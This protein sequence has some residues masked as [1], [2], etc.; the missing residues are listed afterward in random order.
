M[1]KHFCLIFL[2]GIVFTVYSQ[3]EWITFTDPRPSAPILRVI[4]STNQQVRFDIMIP[5]MYQEDTIIDQI[6][7][8]RLLIPQTGTWGVPGYPELPSLSKL[9]AVPECDSIT[10]SFQV[11]DSV[12]LSSYLVFPKPDI[13]ED[14]IHSGLIEVFFKN[15]SI[16]GLNATFPYFNDEIIESGYFRNQP[17]IR[18][19]GYPMHFNPA[20]Q[21]LVVYTHIDVTL[22]FQ[23]PQGV[24]NVDNGL[25]NGIAQGTLLNY[26]LDK[27]IAPPYPTAQIQWITMSDPVEA[28]NIYAD[29]LIITDA[30]FFTPQH[31][32]ALQEIASHRASY[33]GYQIAIVNVQNIFELDFYYDPNY[34][35]FMYEQKIRSFIKR[36]YEG[37]HAQHTLDG[38][39][40]Y[41][42]LV[43]DA[44][45][46]GYASLNYGVPT[47]NDF[48]PGFPT[49]INPT[50]ATCP[51]DYYYSCLTKDQN[52]VWDRQGDIFIGR[53]CTDNETELTNLVSKTIY[54]ENEFMPEGKTNN[55]LT[56]GTI[57]DYS[58][59][60]SVEHHT[61]FCIEYHDWLDGL[62]TN[63]YSTS[64]VDAD[65][66]STWN[67]DFVNH[68]NTNGCNLIFHYGHGD[69]NHW[70]VNGDGLNPNNITISFLEQ[71][72]AN[73]GMNPFVTSI[74][75]FT[76]AFYNPQDDHDC[77]AEELTT[78]SPDKG[79]VAYLGSG[80]AYCLSTH[81]AIANPNANP[82]LI[83]EWI[84]Y[85]IYHDLSF[86]LGESVLESK[87]Q[88]VEEEGAFKMSLIGDPAL[89]LM[90]PG[91]EVT[92]QTSLCGDVTISNSVYV[93]EGAVLSLCSGCNLFFEENGELIVQAGG[94]LVIGGDVTITGKNLTNQIVVYG[95]LEAPPVEPPLPITSLYMTSLPG[96]VWKGIEFCNENLQIKFS[97]CSFTNCTLSGYL[98]KLEFLSSCSFTNSRLD[99]H[100]TNLEITSSTFSNTPIQ[101]NNYQQEEVYAKILQSSMQNSPDDNL[102]SISHYPAFLLDG[103]SL[104]YSEGT[105]IYLEYSG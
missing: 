22:T 97:A 64:L 38:K 7:Y 14:T 29:Y 77:V 15:D 67:T 81:H 51:N 78:Y 74:S 47:S 62:Y 105:G 2:L 42:L 76:G 84:P 61:Y 102:V 69:Y 58:G 39:L 91:F 26:A 33:N 50:T 43:G 87:L 72:L 88:T 86:V 9:I 90:A 40:A 36:V 45:V 68:L 103:N 20:L 53:F 10:I 35:C 96:T 99:L 41:V 19:A 18:I 6:T 44:K 21:Q 27:N 59:G 65:N 46:Y 63:P 31:S 82:T 30:Q 55:L 80:I 17:T 57:Y 52:G 85:S 48:D 89:N 5:G 13:I 104:I 70:S 93:R 3:P 49:N 34:Q 75:C 73:N 94:K 24:V 79:Y 8:Q 23:N 28:D 16:Y 32:Q 4:S 37:A 92:A 12:V 101:L 11:L 95:T 1:K 25:F 54:S 100:E 60:I 66:T 71:N 83:H 98:D 56:Y